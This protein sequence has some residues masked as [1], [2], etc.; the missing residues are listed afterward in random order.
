MGADAPTLRLVGDSGERGGDPNFEG[1]R[2]GCRVVSSM[3][4]SRA[5]DR[6][7]VKLYN[8]R[9]SHFSGLSQAVYTVSM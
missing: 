7:T 4:G 1:D 8:G 2:G 3:S 6:N 5:I 9:K